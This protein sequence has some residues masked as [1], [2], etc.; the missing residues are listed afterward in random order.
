MNL[1]S[2]E[3]HKAPTFDK[4]EARRSVSKLFLSAVAFII[5]ASLLIS[6]VEI[7]LILLIG[8]NATIELFSD[9]SFL[10]I[11]QVVTMYMIAFPIFLV[12]TKNLTRKDDFDY[13][14]RH[15]LGYNNFY[16]KLN[17]KD[18]C[19]R[20]SFGEFIGLFF[21]CCTVMIFGSIISEALISVLSGILG[22][23]ISNATSDLLLD[24]PVGMVILVAVVIGP[25]IEEII[26]RKVFIDVL[27]VYGEKFGIVLSSLAF[28]FFHGNL[29]QLLYATL[30]G[31]ILGYIYT[32]MFKDKKCI[33]EKKL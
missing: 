18:Y 4:K 22:H 11:L 27:G 9:P 24:T 33:H 28:G 12:M 20:I 30:L 13:I 2:Y 8:V 25:I 7:A 31:F 10:L 14:E 23:N 1:N 15:E 3:P 19:D 6:V 32:M 17:K 16:E 26:F 5:I 21:V 29:S